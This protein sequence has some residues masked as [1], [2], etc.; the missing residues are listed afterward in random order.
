MWF[1]RCNN[2]RCRRPYQV[3]EFGGKPRGLVVAE[4]ITCPHCGY[5]ETRWSESRFLAHALSAAEEAAYE[6]K[7]PTRKSASSSS[8]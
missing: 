2:R 4:E 3:N 6:V 5:Q 7:Y 8:E 1:E